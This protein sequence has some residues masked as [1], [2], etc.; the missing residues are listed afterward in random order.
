MTLKGEYNAETAYAVGDVVRYTNN[1][2]Y[3]CLRPTKA[4]TNCADSFYWNYLPSPL[5]E[6]AKMI[7]DIAATIPTNISDEAITLK[8]ETAEY[9][10]TVDDSDTPELVV[11]AIEEES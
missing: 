10:M 11:E 7:M 4:G 8:T 5:Q 1:L 6:C 3:H 9:L 2:F